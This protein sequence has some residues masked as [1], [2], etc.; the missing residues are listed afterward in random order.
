M[1][2]V[3]V[4]CL[5]AFIT[6]VAMA[7]PWNDPYPATDRI[8]N[9]RYSTFSAQPKTL[10]PARSY[11]AEE[12]LIIGQIYEP[13]LQYHYLKRPY[14]LIPQTSD[15]MPKVDYFDEHDQPMS[16]DSTKIA[17]SVYTIK[18]KPKIYFAPHPALARDEH[19]HDDYLSI[20]RS[21]WKDHDYERLQ[22]F[23]HIGTRELT[24]GDYVYQ[25]KRLAHPGIQS[26][27]LG[28]MSE[29]IVGLT[30]YAKRLLPEYHENQFLDL[31][32]F[33]FPGA[34]IVD[35]YTYQIKIIGKY[36][37]FLYWLAMPFFS[38]MPWEADKFNAQPG[39]QARN[40]VLD[41]YPI[42]T[43]PFQLI[44][45]N[46]NRQMV[47]RRNPFYHGDTYPT[48]GSPGDKEKGYLD[49]AGKPLPMID[50]L[51]MKLEKESIPLWSKFLQG[52]YDASGIGPD[53]F[54]QAITLQSDGSLGLTETMKNL[55]LRLVTE[56]EPTIGY[57]GFNML[58]PVVGGYTPQAKKLRQAISILIDYDEYIVIFL[59]GQG[60]TAQGP[61]APGIFGYRDGESG[62]NPIVYE[63]E[64][65]RPKRKSTDVAKKLLVEAGYP[66]GVDPKTH[67]N[68]VLNF[69]TP[70]TSGPDDKAK[71]DWLRKQFAKG[72]IQ[73][74]IRST[75]YNRFQQIVRNG[76]AQMFNWGWHADYPDPENFLFLLYGPNGKAKN[77]GENASNYE[78]PQFDRW[79]EQMKTMKNSPERQAIIDQ[80]INLLREDAPWAWGY[81]PKTL[82]L[83][84]QWNHPGKLNS[85]AQ[86]SLKYIRLNPVLRAK[87]R[88]EW[89]QPIFWPL[90]I[91]LLVL[92]MSLVPVAIQYVRK[93][94]KR[95]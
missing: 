25:I 1:K 18:I 13:P 61:L 52:Y 22:D 84:H 95:R 10:D 16:E 27:I 85:I 62:I 79:Y 70:A 51:I 33:D 37:Q 36:P 28:L 26:S 73:L 53:N 29:H 40:I 3:W 75:Q 38:P 80:I 12:Y 45:N 46:P 88:E 34:K 66:N 44:D 54:N 7:Q 90:G 24:A 8:A 20:T 15:G 86:N 50:M 67:Q 71:F 76:Q 4:G 65:G 83:S 77:G 49:D 48:E 92:A 59:S 91:L 74:N 93:E 57:F 14:E 68:L 47:L 72:G 39:M 78:N 35:R 94:H 17:Y 56:V 30:E 87:L 89:N 19:G 81:H 64:H 55:K 9:V 31:R 82:V 11:M 58:D 60:V 41:W 69:D 2:N 63:W 21:F 23:P 5:L 6:S 42:G 32:Q 43:G